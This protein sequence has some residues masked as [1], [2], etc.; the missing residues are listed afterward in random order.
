MF[1]KRIQVGE[2]Q[3]L[4]LVEVTDNLTIKGW[5]EPE[6]LIC[7]QPSTPPGEEQED[8]LG[9]EESVE[10]PR[11]SVRD[12]CEM[13]VPATLPV[14]IREA[15]GNMAAS[16]L[17]AALN[18]EQVRG[19]LK[20]S[21]VLEAVLAEV[22]GNLKADGVASLRLVGT[23]YGDA[24]VKDGG[25]ADLQN[26]RGN[27]QA[28]RL[29]RLR[30]SRVSGNLQAKEI[31]GALD[32]DQ[33]GGNALLSEIGG[34]VTLD[35]VAGNLAAKSLTGGAKVPKIGGNLVLNG[36]LGQ[37]CTYHFQARGNAVLRLSEG[38]STHVALHAGGMI[39]SSLSLQDEERQGKGLSGTL[40]DGGAELVV[41][42]GGNV[43]LGGG[44]P[45]FGADL[46]AEISRQ[47]EESLRAIDL[48]AIGRQVSEEM[49]SAMSRLQVKLE[50]MDWQRLGLQ[51]QR[52]V[53]RGM[54]QMRKNMDR[55]VEKAARHQERMERRAERE[56]QRLER[57]GR[58]RKKVEEESDWPAAG[59]AEWADDEGSAGMPGPDLEE[60]RLSI[61]RMVEQG[62]ITPAEAEMLLDAIAES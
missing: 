8:L 5:D 41:E 9:I 56:A 1:E 12:K 51:T 53:E 19:N 21:D 44:G 48:E 18:A 11:L 6:V 37:G 28:K 26:V 57:L 60:E 3:H 31:G 32:A 25:T 13:Q 38:A 29:E 54:E 33:V 27:L 30:A 14:T 23:V 36:E 34:A 22:Y 46:G 43:M 49:E 50:G 61:L 16:G 24:N 7:M 40:G 55:T 4:T 20:L 42:A 15:R 10:G 2:G 45:A 39:A 58:R 35:Q 62:Q 52:A 59:A 17:Q 47:V